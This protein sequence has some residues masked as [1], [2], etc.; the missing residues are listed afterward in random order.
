MC[1]GVKRATRKLKQ[2]SF[3]IDNQNAECRETDIEFLFTAYP[4]AIED[5]T[6]IPGASSV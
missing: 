2:E 4:D 3:L 6:I 1:K 5:V